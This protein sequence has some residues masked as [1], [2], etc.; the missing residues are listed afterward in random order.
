MEPELRRDNDFRQPSELASPK[1]ERGAHLATYLRAQ[2]DLVQF[3]AARRIINGLDRAGEIAGYA[4]VSAVIL[5]LH[6]S[7]W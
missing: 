1:V 4:S 3:T 7:L 2:S 6:C 5:V